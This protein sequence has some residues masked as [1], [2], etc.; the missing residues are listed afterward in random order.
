MEITYLQQ[1]FKMAADNSCYADCIIKLACQI[2]GK[3]HNLTNIGKALDVAFDGGF[4]DVNRKDYSDYY[5]AFT[6]LDPAGFLSSL[7]GKTFEVRKENPS[8]SCKKGEFEVLFYALSPEN[9]DKGIGHFVFKG[10]DPLK[11]SNTVL[12][13]SVYSKRIFKEV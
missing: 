5:R 9:A 7:T 3:S 1:F 2:T 12:K 4:V 6:V 11:T 8:Y 13:G 10:Y